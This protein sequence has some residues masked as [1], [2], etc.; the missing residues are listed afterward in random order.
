VGPLFFEEKI[1]AENEQNL[2]TQFIARCKR[3]NRIIAG[4]SKVG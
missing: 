4:F 2:L 1:E 3:M